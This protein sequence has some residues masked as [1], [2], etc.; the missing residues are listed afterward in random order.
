M[1]A[2]CHGSLGYLL[3]SLSLFFF[4]HHHHSSSTQLHLSKTHFPSLPNALLLTLAFLSLQLFC[5]LMW[6]YH[7]HLLFKPLSR[8]LSLSFTLTLLKS[9]FIAYLTHLII[10]EDNCK[11]SC[12]HTLLR[13]KPKGPRN[14]S[15]ER[16]CQGTCLY[17]P[18]CDGYTVC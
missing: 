3:I 8:F 12:P 9:L 15:E 16:H 17:L 11:A 7:P 10:W 5:Y 4:L 1:K 14:W 6:I 13:M 18:E 2:C